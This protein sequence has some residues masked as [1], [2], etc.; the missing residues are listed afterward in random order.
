MVWFSQVNCYHILSLSP[1][2]LFPLLSALLPPFSPLLPFPPLPL[3]PLPLLSLALLFLPPSSRPPP[4]LPSTLSPPDLITILVLVEQSLCPTLLVIGQAL[5]QKTT[6]QSK[7]LQAR[8]IIALKHSSYSSPTPSTSSSMMQT[9]L[10][11]SEWPTV[12]LQ[13]YSPDEVESST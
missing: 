10:E 13:R 4:S 6:L 12:P 7:D 11:S 8:G 1:L 9:G 2:P 3:P 5:F